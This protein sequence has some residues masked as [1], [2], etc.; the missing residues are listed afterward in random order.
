MVFPGNTLSNSYMKEDHRSY[1]RNFCSCEKTVR[2][3]NPRPLRYLCS[4]LPLIII[5][6]RVY[7]EPI[8]RP[9]PCWLVS[10][11]GKN[12]APVSQ[13]SRVRILYK[14]ELIFR[15]SFRNC[16]SC[17]YNCDDLL[18]YKKLLISVKV[19]NLCPPSLQCHLWNYPEHTSSFAWQWQVFPLI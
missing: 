11:V 15:L 9:A 8:Q 3:S 6:S 19:N 7:N 12:A 10:S 5:L 17:V 14:P 16:K 2:H 1:R 13:M 4:A 18:S